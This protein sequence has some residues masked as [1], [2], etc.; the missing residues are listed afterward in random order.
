MPLAA[1][2][3]LPGR[4]RGQRAEVGSI[5]VTVDSGANRDVSGSDPCTVERS[6]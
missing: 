1:S 6:L 2:S 3:I 5:D 4:Q